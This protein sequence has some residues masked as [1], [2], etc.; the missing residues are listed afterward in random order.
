MD[1]QTVEFDGQ[2]WRECVFTG[3][4]QKDMSI[5]PIEG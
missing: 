3:Y 2:H 1:F 5:P 4:L